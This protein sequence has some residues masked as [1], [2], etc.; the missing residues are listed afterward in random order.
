MIITDSQFD[1][2]YLSSYFLDID[3]GNKLYPLNGIFRDLTDRLKAHNVRTGA[4]PRKDEYVMTGELSIWARD[5]MPVQVSDRRFVQFTYSPDYLNAKKYLGH[6]PDTGWI[7]RRIA[8]EVQLSEGSDFYLSFSDIVLDG[9]N[10]VRCGDYVVMTEKIFEENPGKSP[11]RLLDQLEAI[12][13]A[14]I[15]LLP[16]DMR[17]TYGH[18]DGLL[19]YVGGNT[20]VYETYGLPTKDNKDRRFNSSFLRRL[21]AKLDVRVL[22]FSDIDSQHPEE[23]MV[24]LRWAYMNWLQVGS[25]VIMPEFSQTPLS[26]SYAREFVSDAFKDAGM[27]AVIE[28]VEATDLVKLGGCFNC[29]SWTVRAPER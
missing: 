21:A 22:D 13:G 20:V 12:F 9:G 18:T 8:D 17:E 27:D 16:W 29:A 2:V 4:V 7:D 1:T 24:D 15:I 11:A 26:N 25:L 6:V 23:Q 19:R 10:L 5:Y 14:E 28:S 3:K